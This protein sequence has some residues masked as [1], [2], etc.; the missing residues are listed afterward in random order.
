MPK[1]S[2]YCTGCRETVHARAH[3][4]ENP[5][6]SFELGISWILVLASDSMLNENGP[7]REIIGCRLIFIYTKV[8]ASVPVG[9][10][11]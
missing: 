10:G 4:Q 1:C 2:S 5:R 9:Y 3:F 8:K 7:T 6:R 11:R